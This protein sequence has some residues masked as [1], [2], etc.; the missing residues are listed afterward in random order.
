MHS[1]SSAKQ[2]STPLLEDSDDQCIPQLPFYT[3]GFA[4]YIT[5][6]IKG[7][8]LMPLISGNQLRGLV[9]ALGSAGG[10]VGGTD[11]WSLV[12]HLAAWQDEGALR[13]EKL[14]CEMPVSKPAL[15]EFM[16][17]IRPYSIIEAR[18]EDMTPKGAVVLEA[19]Q[20][21]A[22]E[23]RELNNVRNEL[24]TPVRIDT[25]H[26]GVLELDRRFG[27]YV[28]QINWC[29]SNITLNLSCSDPKA[30]DAAL[31]VAEALFSARENWS[32][33]VK[34][35]AADRL[36]SLK[37]DNWLQDDESELS[38]GEFI[39]RMTLKEI[40]IDESG[41]FTFWH[42]DG[43]LFW[44]HTISVSGDITEGLKDADIPG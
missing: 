3:A 20:V 12:F 11:R 33:H 7:S 40:S 8:Y 10:S 32:T 22:G 19:V 21:F 26:F 24:L 4:V 23:D 14:R 37:N 2:V 34:E 31:A 6:C 36:L 17:L 18:I 16:K 41:S 28:G 1:A 42:A 30:P 39:S 9:D 27:D 43:D 44:G 13:R 5:L 15:A 29:G 38:R 35:F 25:P